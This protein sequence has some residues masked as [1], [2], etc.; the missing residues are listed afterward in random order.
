MRILLIA[1]FMSASLLGISQENV[2]Y[3]TTTKEAYAELEEA[4]KDRKDYDQAMHKFK[5]SIDSGRIFLSSNQYKLRLSEIG[6]VPGYSDMKVY[7]DW[8][9]KMEGFKNKYNS[10]NDFIKIL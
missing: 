9:G 2:E 4:I 5:K 7:G 1:I 8:K 3:E 10:I 6:E